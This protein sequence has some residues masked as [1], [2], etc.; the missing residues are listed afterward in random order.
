M[1]EASVKATLAALINRVETLEAENAH[2]R[3]LNA[4]CGATVGKL[5]SKV[6]NQI[7][8]IDEA[9]DR[10]HRSLKDVSTKL[11]RLDAAFEKDSAARK[12][13]ARAQEFEDAESHLGALESAH[14]NADEALKEARAEEANCRGEEKEALI[15]VLHAGQFSGELNMLSGRRGMAR[16]R[17]RSDG[18]VIELDREQLANLLTKAGSDVL[19]F[20]VTARDRKGEQQKFDST[21]R[22]GPLQGDAPRLPSYE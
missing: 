6:E 12:L 5:V 20:S 2:L 1:D 14:R 17:A 10:A 11:S 19:P 3:S 8:D 13:V 7:A 21:L 15:A 18:E 16:I 4:E 22:M 9:R